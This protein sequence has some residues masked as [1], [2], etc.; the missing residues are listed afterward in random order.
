MGNK[1]VSLYS[2][3]VDARITSY[4][5]HSHLVP[6]RF[7]NKLGKGSPTLILIVRSLFDALSSE[8]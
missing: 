8:A 7:V 5:K 6:F 1:P 2:V 4:H 3:T